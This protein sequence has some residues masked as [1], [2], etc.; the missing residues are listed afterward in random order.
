MQVLF[1]R[2]NLQTTATP[3]KA[4]QVL[5]IPAIPACSILLIPA[6]PAC[7]ACNKQKIFEEKNQFVF[8]FIP[9]LTSLQ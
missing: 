6:I 9:V 3:K 1:S 2:Q 5:L 7:S 8:L 4:R